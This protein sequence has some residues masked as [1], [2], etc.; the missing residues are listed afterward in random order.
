[1]LE[2]LQHQLLAAKDSRM[3]FIAHNEGR[4]ETTQAHSGCRHPT[5]WIRLQERLDEVLRVTSH[6]CELAPSSFGGEES[7]AL[8]IVSL[9]VQSLEANV[10]FPEM[11]ARNSSCWNM[12]SPKPG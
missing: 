4:F 10:N 3:L 5:V 11:I 9:P 7:E 6:P 12:S 8:H 2:C 1:M